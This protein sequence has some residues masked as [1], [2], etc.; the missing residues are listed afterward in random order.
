MIPTAVRLPGPDHGR[1]GAERA[2]RARRRGQDPGRRA[3]PAAGAPDA[4]QR[5]GDG[6]RPRPDRLA[7]RRP[8]RRRRDRDR[9]DDPAPE[10]G[11]DTLVAEH[12]ALIAKAVEHLADAQIRHRGTFGGA[13][14]HADPAG[15]L[16]A[17]ALALGAEFVIAG[18]G[19]H[20]HRGGGRLLRRP[21]RDRDRRGRDPHRG[22]DPQAHRLGRALREV[23]PG[24]PPV[25]DRRGRGDG[26]DGRRHHR[27]GAGRAD[28]HGLDADAGVARSRRRSPGRPAT[29]DGVRAAADAGRRGHQPALGPQRRRRLPPPPRHG[30]DPPRGRWPRPEADRGAGPPVHRPDRGR[31]DLGA[32]RGHRRRSR[33][34]SPAPTVTSVEGDD[35]RRL[36][37]GQARTDRARLQRLGDVHGEGRGRAPVR[38]RRQGQGQARQRYRRGDGDAWRWCRAPRWDRRRRCTPTWR[39]PASPRSSAAGVMQDVSDKLL[40][41][42]VACLEQR[43]GAGAR[44]PG[45]GRHRTWHDGGLDGGGARVASPRR[46]CS[47]PGGRGAGRPGAVDPA[48][49]GRSTRRRQRPR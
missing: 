14:A 48:A 40:G 18:P 39:S 11:S 5:P 13:L 9:R 12:A 28:Q 21:V 32:L 36:V 15:D 23:R 44:R 29:D 4:A 17:P 3:E 38:R 45:P 49:A 10:V 19:R 46:R 35:V 27:R 34:A 25:A 47:G 31:G 7:A 37:Q 30:A 8:R 2:R 41:Q 20:P 26:P 1:G 43:L 22:P 33:S 6:H 42:F 24:R 16:G